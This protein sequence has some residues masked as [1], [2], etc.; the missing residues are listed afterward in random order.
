MAN[1][2]TQ[3]SQGF[4]VLLGSL[5]PYIDRELGI[6]FGSNWWDTAVMD[7]LYDDQKRDLPS[8]LTPKVRKKYEDCS[9]LPVMVVSGHS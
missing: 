7:I 5:A 1:N 4:R 6:E 9:E 3:V 8:S 2:H